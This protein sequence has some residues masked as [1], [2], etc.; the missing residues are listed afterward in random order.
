MEKILHCE[1]QNCINRIISEEHLPDDIANLIK[2]ISYVESSS[3]SNNDNNYT[4]EL[5]TNEKMPIEK[6]SEEHNGQ[7]EVKLRTDYRS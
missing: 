2:K 5:N 1:Q 3:N 6:N 7:D 4:D